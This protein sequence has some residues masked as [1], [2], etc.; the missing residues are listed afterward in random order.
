MTRGTAFYIYQDPHF[1]LCIAE[2]TEFNGD[3]YASGHGQE[4]LDMLRKISSMDEFIKQITIF[5]RAHFHYQEAGYQIKKNDEVLIKTY[6][7][8]LVRIHTTSDFTPELDGDIN[9]RY[10]DYAFVKNATD[11]AIQCKGYI[12]EPNDIAIIYM[13]KKVVNQL[14]DFGGFTGLNRLQP[15]SDPQQYIITFRVSGPVQILVNAASESEAIQRAEQEMK[16]RTNRKYKG[17]DVFL[18]DV[19]PA[20]N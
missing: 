20:R 16:I 8:P 5:N 4:F 11:H 10:S 9:R 12:I 19:S 3:M 7:Q 18:Q 15:A 6:P 17:F 14:D 2:S 1:G 13:T